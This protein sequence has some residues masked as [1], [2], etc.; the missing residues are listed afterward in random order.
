MRYCQQCGAALAPHSPERPQ[1]Q[2]ISGQQA[3]ISSQPRRPSQWLPWIEFLLGCFG[4]HGLMFFALDRPR[5]ALGWIAFSLF[6]FAIRIVAI[7]FT[8]GTAVVC[9]VPA[10]F[11]VSLYVARSVSRAMREVAAPVDVP[12]Q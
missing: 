1:P 11:L 3:F 4:L 9:A 6:W 12:V 10:G 7:T 8:G 5:R 2:Y